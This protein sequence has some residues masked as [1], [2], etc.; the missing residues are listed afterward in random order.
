MASLYK[1]PIVVADPKTGRK[2][3]QNHKDEE[4]L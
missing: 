1:K 3:K 2:T 4:T